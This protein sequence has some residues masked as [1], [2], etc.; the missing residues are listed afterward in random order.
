MTDRKDRMF[1]RSK[2]I[3][4]ENRLGKTLPLSNSSLAERQT[5]RRGTSREGDETVAVGMAGSTFH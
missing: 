3:V 4:I 5:V 1:K 2:V